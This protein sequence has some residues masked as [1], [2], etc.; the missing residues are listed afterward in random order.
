MA[1]HKQIAFES[2]I[3]DITNELLWKRSER[4]RLR[5]K[6]FAL[7]RYLAEYPGQLVTKS[8]LLNAIWKNLHAGDEALKHCVAAMRKTLD[9]PSDAPKFVEK[10]HRRG[11]RFIGKTSKQNTKNGKRSA[12]FRARKQAQNN[13]QAEAYERLT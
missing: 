10:V 12:D 2:F 8:E 9:D 7:L 13:R 6:T 1:G 11:Y 4:I 3:L 5:P